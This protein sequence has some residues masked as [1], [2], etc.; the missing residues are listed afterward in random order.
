MLVNESL[1]LYIHHPSPT[2]YSTGLQTHGSNPN[3]H[4]RAFF[5]RQT[6]SSEDGNGTWYSF[7]AYYVPD[8]LAVI[9]SLLSHNG[10]GQYYS[11]FTDEATEFQKKES[12]TPKIIHPLNGR[13]RIQTQVFQTPKLEP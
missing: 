7:S 10:L 6:S 11:Q 13:T 8:T 1:D 4:L 9:A 3:W 12:D 5:P 2:N